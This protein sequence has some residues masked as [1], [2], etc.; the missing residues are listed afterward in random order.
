MA[1]RPFFSGDYGSA[2]GSYDTAARLLAQA[3]QTQGAAMA[4]L[5]GNIAG[6]IEKY[7]LNKE[8]RAVLTGEVEAMLPDYANDLTMTGDED[9]DKKNMSRIE[10]FQR[11]DM[12][13]ADL[14]GFAGELARMEKRKITQSALAKQA[15]DIRETEAKIGYYGR[16]PSEKAA[17]PVDPLKDEQ[18]KALSDFRRKLNAPGGGRRARGPAGDP[19]RVGAAGALLNQPAPAQPGLP[20]LSPQQMQPPLAGTYPPLP[21]SPGT[22]PAPSPMPPRT[23]AVTQAMGAGRPIKRNKFENLSRKEKKLLRLARKNPIGAAMMDEATGGAITDIRTRTEGYMPSEFGTSRDV[24]G[25][26]G[27]PSGLVMIVTGKDSTVVQAAPEKKYEVG[28]VVKL[29]DGSSQ[30]YMGNNKFVALVKDEFDTREDARAVAMDFGGKVTYNA[31]T[32]GFKKKL[33]AF[34]KRAKPSARNNARLTSLLVSPLK[35]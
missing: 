5:G 9:E 29:E 17:T 7:Q 19:G 11:N 21:P 16:M 10:K 24:S 32:G 20:A 30:Q 3:G 23:P 35:R 28:H 2:L 15:A 26:D 8:K 25:A 4:G 13:M 33:S 27:N 34:A 22:P 14:K 18:A 31:A 12:S 6:A 1:R